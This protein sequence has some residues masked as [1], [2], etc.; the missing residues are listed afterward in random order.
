MVGSALAVMPAASAEDKQ[1]SEK[2]KTLYIH[3]DGSEF[4]MNLNK[5]ADSTSSLY[6]SD[7]NEYDCPLDPKLSTMVNFDTSQEVDIVIF[8]SVGY[9]G[10]AAPTSTDYTATIEA[11]LAAGSK[12]IG[13]G[14]GTSAAMNA[15]TNI[16][17]PAGYPVEIKFNPAVASISPSDGNLNLHFTV[18]VTSTVP[19]ALGEGCMV[20]GQDASYG[21]STVKLPILSVAGGNITGNE[22]AGGNET[23]NQTSGNQNSGASKTP[24]FE[25]IAIIGAVGIAALVS[26]RRKC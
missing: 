15:I 7:G 3:C 21:S 22:T 17:S 14:S 6:A 19:D 10:G 13:S 24:G 9:I 25:T 2:N 1:L 12:T 23:G 20:C 26:R 8:V 11:T 5:A 4:K 16:A 18:S